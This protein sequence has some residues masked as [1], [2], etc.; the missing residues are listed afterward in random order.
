MSRFGAREVV[1]GAAVSLLAL[2]VFVPLGALFL[3]L[4]PDALAVVARPL[5]RSAALSTFLL[6]VGTTLTALVLGLPMGV[7]LA[8]TDLPGAR[9]FRVLVTLPWVVP[10]YVG[11]I[12]W[13]LLTNPTTGWLNVPLKAVGLPALDPYNLWGMVWV[14]G[15][16]ATPLV[17]LATADALSRMDAS[18]EE[19]AR[20]A[21]CSPVQAVVRVTLPL[22]APSVLAAAGFVASGAA[23]AYGVPYLLA[24][25]SSRPTWVLTTRIAQ[26]LDLDPASGR[27]V[28]V[29]L[30]LVLLAIGVGLP[31]LLALWIRGRNFTTVR[32]KVVRPA[33]LRLGAFRPVA[34]GAMVSFVVIGSALPLS[35][36]LVASV[37]KNVGRGLVSENLT[38]E[39]YA[40]AMTGGAAAAFGRSFLLAGGAATGAVLL[41]A[42]IA[43]LEQRT[44]LRGRG[45]VATSARLPYA[46]PGTV[47][48]LAL[49]LAWS[50]EVRLVV[51]DRVSFV[52]ALSDTLWMLGLA[53][54]VK[55][56]ALPVGQV[57]A[58]LRSVDVS[59]EE[60]ARVA[61]AGWL[62][63]AGG[64]TFRLLLPAL[65]STWILVFL[66]SFSEVTMSV[67]LSGP[68]TRVVGAMLFDLQTYG[69]PPA[70][71]A[72]AVLV[73]VVVVAGQALGRRLQPE[74]V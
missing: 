36:L 71:A 61:G 69:D 49:L 51:L 53:Y 20:I 25:G 22:V 8:R 12:G 35:A 38:L 28:A 62:R 18:L 29:A 60:A 11:A 13:L 30:S 52:L 24:S 67:L 19:Q 48:A 15:L 39:H 32:G 65:V 43:Y 72:L 34:V 27:P 50:Q 68:R 31:A 45:A 74:Q 55:F 33:P 21:G 1:L 57:G 5:E 26:Q 73:T 58:A 6:S 46:V 40:S 44:N 47:L 4:T 56:L 2:F 23:A 10:P 70:A 54:L 16:E 59:L 64:V 37:S 17:A 9:I 41:G 42:L 66:P 3:Q 7:L 63:A 14:M